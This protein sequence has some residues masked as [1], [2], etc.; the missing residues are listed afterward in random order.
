VSFLTYK[1]APSGLKHGYSAHIEQYRGLCAL[2]VLLTHGLREEHMLVDN[3][4]WPEY[5][6]YCNSG[7][8]SVLVF[9]CISGYVIGITND[10]N[11]LDIKSYLKKRVIRLYPIY[12]VAIVLCIIAAGGVSLHV[13]LGNLFFLQNQNSYFGW[14]VPIF[15]NYPAWSLNYEVIYY[16]LFIVI[17]YL[18]PKIWIMTLLLLVPTLLLLHCTQQTIFLS[19]YIHGY[20]FWILGLVIGWNIFKNKTTTNN[21]PLLSMLFLQLCLSHLYQG[22]VILHFL[23]IYP[24]NYVGQLFDFPFCLMIMCT[25]T[26][27]DNVFLRVNKLICYALPGCIL[28]FLVVNHRILEDVRWVM[29]LIFWVLSLLFYFEKKASSFLLGQLTGI[30]KISYA[31]YLFHEP[32]AFLVKK[33]IFIHNN[34]IAEVIIKYILWIFITF[35]LSFVLERLV[36]PVI[37]KYLTTV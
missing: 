11:N 4:K 22:D 26:G 32:V 1:I 13:L 12:L 17:F 28:L 8:L 21:I 20:Y 29:C 18:K 15:L 27:K 9:F 35:A 25:L 37:K 33:V 34:I 3:F 7:S 24:T 23:G 2:L 36:Q 19:N 14:Q 10:K 5:L 30:G 6:R 31:L 16:L